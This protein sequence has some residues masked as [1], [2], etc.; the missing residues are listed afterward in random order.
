[1][2]TTLA[3]IALALVAW[4]A[5]SLVAGIAVG[6]LLRRGKPAPD[7]RRHPAPPRL[8]QPAA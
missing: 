3:L 1:M 6:S 8:V 5:F 7:V 4:A 2:L